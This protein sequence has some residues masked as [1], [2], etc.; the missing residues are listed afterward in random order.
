MSIFRVLCSAT[1]IHWA[2]YE[3]RFEVNDLFAHLFDHIRAELLNGQGAN[4]S[5]ELANHG[6]TETVVVQIKDVLHDL[7]NV[8]IS[9]VNDVCSRMILNTYIVAIRVLHQGKCIVRDFI[10]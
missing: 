6:I 2:E 10:N 4:V 7:T 3:S 9:Q 8:I 1:R 5:G